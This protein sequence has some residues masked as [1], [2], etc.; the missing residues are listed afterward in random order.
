MYRLLRPLL[1]ALPPASAHELA[2]LALGAPERL[3]PLRALVR[4]A[5]AVD[6]P[7]LA[8]RTMGLTFPNPVGLAA[9]FDKDGRRPRALAALGFGH[10]EL[11]TVTARA[12]GE[13]PRPNLFRLPQDEALVNRLGFP[14][15]GAARLAARLRGLDAPVP[16][17]VS[18]GK[19]RAIDPSD[20]DAVG[21]DYEESFVAVAPVADFVVVNVSSPNTPGLRA[22]QRAESAR[23]LLARLLARREGLA[24]RPPLLL[25]VAPDLGPDEY[26]ALLDVVAGL[27]LDGL[28]AANTTV[29]RAALA[30]P[31]SEVEAAGAGGLSG[32]PLRA[33][34]LAMVRRAR[35]RLG[36]GPT[37]I[38][39]GGVFGPDDVR[40]LLDAGAD[41]C[42]LYTGFVYRGP[43]VARAICR[44]LAAAPP[45]PASA[46]AE[47]ARPHA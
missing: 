21:A 1:F 24:K 4:A 33:R 37:V 19:S 31:A 44:D 43:G 35:E 20:P 27:R 7:R 16:V 23:G 36:P 6:E 46:R 2:M 15:A 12:Q 45:P 26:D 8:V 28:V 13:N 30:T 32:K 5:L 9:G 41:L 47:A 38:G 39:V 11:G 34:A 22:M 40:A 25:K 17:G 3:P 10:L 42:Q 29:A 14:N 18:I